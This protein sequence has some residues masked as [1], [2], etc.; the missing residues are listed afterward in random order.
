MSPAQGRRPRKPKL[1]KQFLS[2]HSITLYEDG[3]EDRAKLPGY[4][5]GVKRK[6]LNFPPLPSDFQSHFDENL[7]KVRFSG[8]GEFIEC[9]SDKQERI[10]PVSLKP[11][12]YMYCM[13]GSDLGIFG[14]VRRTAKVDLEKSEMIAEEAVELSESAESD[15]QDT[16]GKKLF[17][18]FKC[19]LDDDL[20][21]VR[22]GHHNTL[23]RTA[24]LLTGLIL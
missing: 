8:W 11:Q 19:T 10:Q 14:N 13:P 23:T 2:R 16:Y 9:W 5:R 15:W 4:V 21:G 20:K 17:K 22:C 3:D 12:P 7:N 6:L 1:D 24:M 18:T